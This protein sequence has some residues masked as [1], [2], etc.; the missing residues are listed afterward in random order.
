M[1]LKIKGY[2]DISIY[3]MCLPPINLSDIKE[4]FDAGVTEFGFNILEAKS[5]SVQA[6]ART[7]HTAGALVL[8]GRPLDSTKKDAFPDYLSI[9]ASVENMLL[10]ATEIGLESLWVCDILDAAD[11]IKSELNFNYELV[12]AVCLGYKNYYGSGRTRKS[13]DKIFDYGEIGN[14]PSN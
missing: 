12:S 6:T 8:V 7:I 14:A 4:Y 10:A 11:E 3:L 1:C 13:L 9:G 2:G 5:T